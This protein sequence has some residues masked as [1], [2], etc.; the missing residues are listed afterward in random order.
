MRS[1]MA[2]CAQGTQVTLGIRLTQRRAASQLLQVVNLY[3]TFAGRPVGST[4]AESTD[5]AVG[6]IVLNTRFSCMSASLDSDNFRTLPPPLCKLAR[7]NLSHEV[8]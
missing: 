8:Q 6:S 5:K 3:E 4:K 2:V 7:L 1:S